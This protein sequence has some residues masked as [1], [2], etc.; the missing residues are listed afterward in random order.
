MPDP[1]TNNS[2]TIP[3]SQS[4][5]PPT[6]PPG[7]PG[8]DPRGWIEPKETFPGKVIASAY[9]LCDEKYMEPNQFRTQRLPRQIWQWDL[10][11]ERLDAVYQLPDGS[12]VPVVRYGGYD[13]ERFNTRTGEIEPTN[14][15]ANKEVL[16][17]GAWVACFGSIE[18]PEQ[19]VG[20]MAEFEFYPSKKLQRNVAKNVLLPLRALTPDYTFVGDKQ[21]FVVTREAQ[22]ARGQESGQ[23]AG[24]PTQQ[25]STI[26]SAEAALAQVPSLLHGKNRNNLS[27]LISSLPNDVRRGDIVDGIIS[28]KLIEQ[29]AQ[30]GLI[31]IG[32]DG[33]LAATTAAAVTAV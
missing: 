13:L 21:V 27:E 14:L 16:I 10:R 5:A 6:L 3:P 31:T 32:A 25:A 2:G 11:I 22:D 9:R 4:A 20:R 29:L 17:G 26:L 12:Q 1:N 8:A 28:G 30:D 23:A 18:P 15:R 33:A 7:V 24:V 19:L